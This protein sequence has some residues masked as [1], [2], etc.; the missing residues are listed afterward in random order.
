MTSGWGE[1]EA[2]WAEQRA[3]ENAAAAETDRIIDEGTA[4]LK[5]MIVAFGE[6]AANDVKE[7]QAEV[8][9]LR[10]KLI[11]RDAEIQFLRQEGLT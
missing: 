1:V 9:M 3:A 2:Q 4:E 7:L 6:N 5:R 11:D 8:A 10:E